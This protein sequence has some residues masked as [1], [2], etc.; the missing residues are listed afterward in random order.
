MKYWLDAAPDARNVANEYGGEGFVEWNRQLR[1][2]FW[3]KGEEDG[4]R[5]GSLDTQDLE[6]LQNF[7]V[8]AP[9]TPSTG[10]LFRGFTIPHARS[11]FEVDISDVALADVRRYVSQFKVGAMYDTQGFQ[12]FSY[13]IDFSAGIAFDPWG[14][15]IVGRIPAGSPALYLY[16]RGESELLLPHGTKMVFRGTLPKVQWSQLQEDYGAANYSGKYPEKW[17]RLRE[18]KNV[19]VTSAEYRKNIRS[20]TDE[21]EDDEYPIPAILLFDLVVPK[22]PTLSTVQFFHRPPSIQRRSPAPAFHRELVVRSLEK[23]AKAVKVRPRV[24]S[25]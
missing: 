8:K 1:Q 15:L 13:D 20:A 25:R 21:T 24:Q 14:V 4:A 23:A 18:P 17:T 9:R 11:E 12:S 19:T 7:I 3:L 22:D 6:V 16:E 5:S 2:P 10:Y